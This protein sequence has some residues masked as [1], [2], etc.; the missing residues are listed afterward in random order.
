MRE[1][2][3]RDI[4]VADAAEL[5][6]MSNR[7]YLRRFKAE[8]GEAPLEYLLRTRFEL[9]CQLLIET[10]LPVDKIARRCGMGNGDRM[11]RLFRR[12]YGLSPTAYRTRGRTRPEDR[13]AGYPAT[14]AYGVVR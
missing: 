1:N 3:G 13:E 11:G 9:I 7:N 2:L 14:Q 4:S 8:F 10:D 12:R 6:A 5:A